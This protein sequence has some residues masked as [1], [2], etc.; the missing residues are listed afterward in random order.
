MTTS[1]VVCSVFFSADQQLGV[2]E[3]AVLTGA[4]LVNRGGVEVD[5]DGARDVFVV[6][7]LVEEGFI[8]TSIADSGVG[9]RTTICL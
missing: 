6:A 3:L 9:V 8:C 2:E 1:I 7:G 4:D 5:E